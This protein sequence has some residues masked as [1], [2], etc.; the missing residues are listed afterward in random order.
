MRGLLSISQCLM[1]ETDISAHKTMINRN[2]I[3]ISGRVGTQGGLNG[4]AFLGNNRRLIRAVI[5]L[6]LSL[7]IETSQTTIYAAKV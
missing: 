4:G 5:F 3:S 2:S 7:L 6:L 1:H